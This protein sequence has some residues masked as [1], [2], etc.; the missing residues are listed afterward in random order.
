MSESAIGSQ[1]LKD[2]LGE[3]E[4]GLPGEEGSNESVNC[5]ASCSSG[6]GRLEQISD[7]SSPLDRAAWISMSSIITFLNGKSFINKLAC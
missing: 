3:F 6:S 2:A 1:G 7:H 5:P 4:C